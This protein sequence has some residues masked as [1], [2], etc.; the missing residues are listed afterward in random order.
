M[1]QIESPKISDMLRKLGDEFWSAERRNQRMM[2]LDIPS[3]EGRQVLFRMVKDAHILVESSK[4]GTWKKW[5]I[6]DEVLWEHNPAL[7]IVHVLRLRPER[8]PG[9]CEPPGLRPRG[10]SP[11]AA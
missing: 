8:R 4:G 7:V 11:S 6:T 10:P 5:G 2:T 1:V 3:Q 9:L